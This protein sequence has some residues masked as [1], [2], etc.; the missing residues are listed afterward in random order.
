MTSKN[1][2]TESESRDP[3]V[4]EAQHY[5][6]QRSKTYREQALK[7]YP[8]ICARCGREFSGKNFAS[9]RSITKTTTTTTIH[10][11]GAT[12]SCCVSIVMKTSTRA[13]R[14]LTHMGR[15][16]QTR[17]DGPRRPTS[18]SPVLRIY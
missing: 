3:I 8:W 12:G 2:H 7:I 17:S 16:R 18:H 11:M 4:V 9:L 1:D 13:I 6:D 14:S 10:A 15:R 5:R